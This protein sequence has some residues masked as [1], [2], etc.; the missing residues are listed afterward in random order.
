M[1]EPDIQ[2][3]LSD[4]EQEVAAL[5]K[6][7]QPDAKATRPA[8]GFQKLSEFL[9]ANWVL[10]SFI[11]TLLI[12]AYGKLHYGVDYFEKFETAKTN[13]ELS[14]F[15]TQMGDRFL[16]VGEFPSAKL[17]Y[18]EALKINPDN[19]KAVW[20]NA[21]A[22][23]FDPPPGEKAWAPEVVDARLDHLREN[24]NFGN[25]YRL[26]FLKAFRYDAVDD[27]DKAMEAI[28]KCFQK[29]EVYADKFFGCYLQRGYIEVREGRPDEAK[30]DFQ[31]A[32]DIDPDHPN[33][34]VLN[35]LAACQFL[36]SDFSGAYQNFLKSYR[37]SPK[38]L[39][40][41]NL[42]E[43]DW[44]LR[45]FAAAL[46]IHQWTA[47]YLD[48]SVEDNDRLL[49]GEWTEPFF[50]L[51]VGDHETIRNTVRIDTAVQKKITFHFVLAIDHALLNEPVAAN[52][53]F[54]IAMKLQPNPDHQSLIQNRM[55]S[56]EN[57][58]QMSDDAKSW[59]DEHRRMLVESAA[60][61]R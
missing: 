37:I 51:H 31:Q 26:D 39:T 9:K 44:F 25:D 22:Q 8:S 34:T 18:A 4:L 58:V 45:D 59:L 27:Q 47:N 23:A 12:A 53:E 24:T 36:M 57:M 14:A 1:E 46:K 43:T 6:T 33:L 61:S 48:G 28:Q 20:G 11:S 5:K 55:Q 10:L 50:P 3:R 2:K 52:N 49:G 13:R 7:V 17:A 30:A 15:H 54:A 38:V 56:V 41:L 16:G 35:D 19:E 42:G 32:A 40:S 21:L 60:A 29:K